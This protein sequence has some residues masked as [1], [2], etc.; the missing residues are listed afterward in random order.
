M[1]STKEPE[2]DNV[3][4]SKGK[5]LVNALPLSLVRARESVMG[6]F[7]NLLRRYDLTEPQWRV[8]RTVDQLAEIEMTE[9]SRV[10]ALLMPSLSCITR[11]LELRGY[12]H[13]EADPADLR[14]MIVRLSDTGRLL[15]EMASPECE[16]VYRAIRHAM[17]ND[18]LRELNA[19]LG[20]LETKLAELNIEF[21]GAEAMPSNIL[22]IVPAK[23]RGR[24]AKKIA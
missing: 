11:E 14:R 4:R 8:L 5:G 20:E 17:G 21:V 7:R 2:Q 13:K 16:A 1:Q 18:K 15:V 23:Q 3:P 22:P 10:T 9:L 24:P 19:L 12:L 6:H